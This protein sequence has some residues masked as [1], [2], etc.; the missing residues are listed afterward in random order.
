MLLFLLKY[1]VKIS[2]WVVVFCP[3]TSLKMFWNRKCGT[4]FCASLHKNFFLPMSLLLLCGGHRGSH[5][6][7]FRY[8]RNA[9]MTQKQPCIF[10]F[11][12]TTWVIQKKKKK[13]LADFLHLAQCLTRRQSNM[14][15]SVFEK[16]KNIMP[17]FSVSQ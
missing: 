5:S 2:M 15:F 8:L 12:F 7:L 16:E 3:Q 6:P 14:N 13:H 10:L 9:R 17:R 1:S 4:S 11:E